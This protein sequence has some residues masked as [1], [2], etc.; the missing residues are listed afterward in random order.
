M[1]SIA[2]APCLSVERS[3]FALRH[4]AS[5][6]T[7][8]LSLAEDY[9]AEATRD[10]LSKASC[11]ASNFSATP[12]LFGTRGAGGSQPRHDDRLH[13]LSALNALLDTAEPLM[14]M[15]S[16]KEPLSK[17]RARKTCQRL[18]P[19]VHFV[20]LIIEACQSMSSVMCQISVP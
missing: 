1:T 18:Q 9:F 5:C 16:P 10:R 15:P 4:A 7:V 11:R 14:S 20:S 13:V 19:P 8:H 17:P 6:L 12:H 3:V 2:V